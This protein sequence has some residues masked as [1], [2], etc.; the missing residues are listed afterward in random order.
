MHGKS[1]LVQRKRESIDNC[2]CQVLA[3]PGDDVVL[4][5]VLG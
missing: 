4:I 1:V 2:R 3:K 5:E